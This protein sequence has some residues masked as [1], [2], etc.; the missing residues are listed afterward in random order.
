MKDKDLLSFEKRCVS[1]NGTGI[2]AKEIEA[3]A[4]TAKANDEAIKG[5]L[6][7]LLRVEAK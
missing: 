6:F 4:A 3:T 2:T 7:Q 5:G 1:A